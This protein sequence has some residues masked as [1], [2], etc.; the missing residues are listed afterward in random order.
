METLYYGNQV[1]SVHQS[2]EFEVHIHSE[3]SQP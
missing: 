3:G 2:Q 1:P